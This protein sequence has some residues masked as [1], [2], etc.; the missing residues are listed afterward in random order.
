[1]CIYYLYYFLE[2]KGSNATYCLPRNTEKREHFTDVLKYFAKENLFILLDL[3][4]TFLPKEHS[5][6]RLSLCK[7]SYCQHS[8]TMLIVPVWAR[9]S[10]Y[11]PHKHIYFQHPSS[12]GSL[13][14]IFLGSLL[15]ASHT[16]ECVALALACDVAKSNF[17]RF[18]VSKTSPTSTRWYCSS[19]NTTFKY[20][21]MSL[22]FLQLVT[23]PEDHTIISMK[24][25]FKI[26]FWFFK[27]IVL[28]LIFLRQTIFFFT[29]KNIV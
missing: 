21:I 11:N 27:N 24:C 5:F 8:S 29:Q 18:S 14:A 25:N 7:C 15:G 1:M 22:K 3:Y 6:N 13:E 23:T 19:T 10:E 17:H 16:S 28:T 20:L 2:S 4:P 9:L 26:L 12:Q